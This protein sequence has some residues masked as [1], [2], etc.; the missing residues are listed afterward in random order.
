MTPDQY[1]LKLTYAMDRLFWPIWVV[2]VVVLVYVAAK[3]QRNW[4]SRAPFYW[5]RV[6][7]VPVLIFLVP[8]V[9]FLLWGVA[10]AY[11]DN[12]YFVE[13][14]AGHSWPL[15]IWPEAG[16]YFPLQ[17]REF[18]L[19]RRISPTALF[20]HSMVAVQLALF[21]W[22]L[23]IALAARIAVGTIKRRLSNSATTLPY[24]RACRATPRAAFTRTIPHASRQ[25]GRSAR[26]SP[27]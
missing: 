13:T 19:L 15:M 22:V 5:P 16:R 8:Y 11:H 25:T 21:C 17:M 1:I 14:A 12:E 23:L 10:F 3:T 9:L 4:L 6:D 24:F 26:L 27:A 18:N 20:Y 2:V 7:A